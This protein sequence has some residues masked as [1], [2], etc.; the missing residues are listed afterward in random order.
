MSHAGFAVCLRLV[1]QPGTFLLQPQAKHLA[2]KMVA[3]FKLCSEQLSSQGVWAGAS[4]Q[5]ALSQ[6]LVRERKQHLPDP[7]IIT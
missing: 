7:S 5:G 1:T 2:R 4:G 3:T 6:V